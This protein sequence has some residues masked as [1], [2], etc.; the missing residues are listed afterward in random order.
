MPSYAIAHL[1]EVT[2]GPEIA[3]Y[4]TRIDATLAAYQGRFLIHGAR[5]EAMEGAW[6]ANVIV[7]EFP[8]RAAACGWYDSP[9]YQAILPLRLNH[10]KGVAFLVDG[11]EPG[12]RAAGLLAALSA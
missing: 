1:H 5:A 8:N 6:E 12:H 11:V 2:M 10:A 4:L 9:A 7:V 3:E